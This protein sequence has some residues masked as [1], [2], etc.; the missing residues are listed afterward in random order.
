MSRAVN[1]SRVAWALLC[2]PNLWMAAAALVVRLVPNDWWRGV[3]PPREYA[4][5]RGQSVYGA[6][7]PEVPPVDLIRYLEW[8]KAFPGPIR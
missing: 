3:T 8:C 1:M 2:R 7:L 6:P 5:Y 4:R